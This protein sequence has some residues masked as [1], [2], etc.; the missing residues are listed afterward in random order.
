M[1]KL[2][3]FVLVLCLLFTACV[4]EEEMHFSVSAAMMAQPGETLDISEMLVNAREDLLFTSSDETVACVDAAGIVTA[5]GEGIATIVALSAGNNSI[6]AYMDVA[7]YDYLG[8]YSGAKFIDAMNCNIELEITLR[9]DGTFNYYRAPMNIAMAGGGEMPALE[10]TGSYAI[11]G[12][13]F[14][15]TSELL[16]EYSAMFV[17]ADGVGSLQGKMPTGGPSTDMVI[18]QVPEAKE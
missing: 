7:V 6:Y 9:E 8:I 11:N 17:L 12:N 14:V 10:D 1:R 13:E 15:F 4:A 2:F 5:V 3:A 16:G 18:A